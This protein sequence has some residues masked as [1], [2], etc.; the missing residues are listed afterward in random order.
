[1]SHFLP[2][3]V[4]LCMFSSVAAAQ[5]ASKTT[6]SGV[7]SREQASRG[8]NVFLATCKSCHTTEFHTT[9]AFTTKW[10]GKALS[11]L[12]QY[13]RDQ[14]PKNEPGSLAA[15]EYA[16][17]LAYMLRL[18][19]MPAGNADLPADA[20]EVKSIRIDLTPIAVRKDP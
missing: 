7:Y 9:A 12:L 8:Q 13:V 18:N 20:T 3:L 4:A 11:E 5:T 16:D 15:D 17:V 1:V 2:A 6:K 14:M 19:R 10:N